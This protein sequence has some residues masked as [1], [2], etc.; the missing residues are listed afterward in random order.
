MQY[1]EFDQFLRDGELAISKGRVD[2]LEGF[3]KFHDECQPHQSQEVSSRLSVERRIK[4]R[5]SNAYYLLEMALYHDDFEEAEK[6]LSYF[7]L[8]NT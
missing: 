4:A 8:A 6:V 1:D 5:E 2:Y 3:V 7:T